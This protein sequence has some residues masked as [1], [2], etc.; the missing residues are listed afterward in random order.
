MTAARV[1]KADQRGAR[2]REL[3]LDA[4]EQLMAEKGYAATP[5]SAI[6][7]A[8][9]VPVT[10]L[11]WHFGSKD[12]LLAT[13]MERGAERWFAS[14]PRGDDRETPQADAEALQVQGADAV[15]ANPNFLRLLDILAIE[16]R[17]DELAATLVHRVRGHAQVYF[18]AAIERLL[19]S[20][21]DTVTAR[22]AA[23]D[24]ARF[25][26]AFSDGCFFA[27]QLELETTDLRQMYA[28]L[29]TAIRALAPAAIGRARN[30][31]EPP[32]DSP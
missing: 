8:A 18:R 21:C 5:V 24:L 13:V 22:V 3:L 11:Y 31:A 12:G 29:T 28:D 19:T 15:A 4:A 9:G 27:L 16:G 1:T 6:C 20:L 25:A 23:D 30:G 10:S 32:Q 26:V 2:S 17:N 7:K 14:L